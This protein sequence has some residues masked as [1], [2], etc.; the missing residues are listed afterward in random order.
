MAITQS[1]IDFSLG[2]ITDRALLDCRFLGWINEKTGEPIYR[3]A[4]IE[5]HPRAY[6]DSSD[7]YSLSIYCKENHHG[8][9]YLHLTKIH[10]DL[11]WS[12][13]LVNGRWSETFIHLRPIRDFCELQEIVWALT[14]CNLFPDE[15]SMKEYCKSVTN[16]N[17]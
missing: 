5:H 14:R 8:D 11:N 1:K 12:C 4:F 3:R 7:V 9:Y 16:N 10:P 2:R 15:W 6:W 13:F 17:Q